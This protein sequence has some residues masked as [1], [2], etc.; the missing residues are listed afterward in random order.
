MQVENGMIMY[1]CNNL[2]FQAL[3]GNGKII[4]RTQTKA[5]NIKQCHERKQQ[6]SSFPRRL[7]ISSQS[8]Q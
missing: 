1:K 8:N 7:E 3:N 2:T 4:K 5:S 6:F